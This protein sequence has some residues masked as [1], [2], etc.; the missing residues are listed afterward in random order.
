MA[1]RDQKSTRERVI[2]TSGAQLYVERNAKTSGTTGHRHHHTQPFNTRLH[3]LNINLKLTV[4]RS[5]L[6]YTRTTFT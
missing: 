4:I 6:K 3:R 1:K 5:Y 2:T